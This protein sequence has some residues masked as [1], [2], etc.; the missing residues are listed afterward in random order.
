MAHWRKK[1][2]AFD[3]MDRLIRQHPGI[4]PAELARQL[5]VAR[6]TVTRRLPSLEEAGYLYS[7][8]DRGGLWP[9]GRR[10]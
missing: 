4:R 2:P 1:V 8:D 6:S 9:F 3:E 5:G 7:E 10:L